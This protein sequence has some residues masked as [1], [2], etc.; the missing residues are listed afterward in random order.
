MTKS[1]AKQL[2]KCFLGWLVWTLYKLRMGRDLFLIIL[3]AN[4]M[5]IA[6]IV[7]DLL[8][9]SRYSN[10]NI[11]V[12]CNNVRMLERISGER[13]KKRLVSSTKINCFIS[14]YLI[15]ST[16]LNMVIA[17]LDMPEGRCG[18]RLIGVKHIT[19]RM[20]IKSLFIDK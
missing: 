15:N 20:L 2:M 18:Y 17:S 1:Y 7:S 11:L 14:Y 8:G 12:A 10:R 5:E 3:D 9:E 4:D 19:K 13:L 16:R 6:D